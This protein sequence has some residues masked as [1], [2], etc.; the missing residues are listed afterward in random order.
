[1]SI[2]VY[3]DN[4]TNKVPEITY[5]KINEFFGVVAGATSV[6]ID[7]EGEEAKAIE[8][9]YQVAK[10]TI[11]SELPTNAT[12]PTQGTE[13]KW[14]DIPDKPEFLSIGTTETTAAAGNH[15]HKVAAD[16]A[17]GLAAAND[18]QSLA[19]ALSTRIK[20]LEDKTVQG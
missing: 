18:I 20:A 11:L 12:P 4:V 5:R 14:G 16:A 6:F 2:V 19:K 10:V 1:M 17:S 9:A 15:N 7:G 8:S 3:S 13:V